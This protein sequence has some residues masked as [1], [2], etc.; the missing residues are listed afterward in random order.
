[1]SDK[2]AV[3]DQITD[4]VT[5]TNVK[6]LGESPAVAIA[7]QILSLSHAHS[8][9]A[10]NAVSSQHHSQLLSLSSIADDVM[11]GADTSSLA[12]LSSKLSNIEQSINSRLQSI[13]S[14]MMSLKSRSY[15]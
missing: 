15:V 14:M 12:S 5:Q 6:V 9:M 10:Y 7:S 2:T 13:E 1:M 11:L 4:A 3:N 8:M